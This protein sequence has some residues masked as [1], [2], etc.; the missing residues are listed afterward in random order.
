MS[1]LGLKLY[2]SSPETL[3]KP[4]SCL[5]CCFCSSRGHHPCVFPNKSLPWGLLCSMTLWCSLAS[6]CQDTLLFRA[7][8]L[9][10]GKH[11]CSELTSPLGKPSLQSCNTC[12]GETFLL[13][14]NTSTGEAFALRALT[15]NT[16]LT[17]PGSSLHQTDQIPVQS[18]TIS[19]YR[20]LGSTMQQITVWLFVIAQIKNHDW[21]RRSHLTIF[22][23]VPWMYSKR[24]VLQLGL[25]LV[26]VL[27]LW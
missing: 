24:Q 26:C 16:V 2:Q 23:K 19:R 10:L 14:A 13:R 17:N 6:E 3:Y 5:P 8:I 20:V 25:L 11:C 21:R 12:T 4:A 22:P 15:W 27:L 18:T 7:V 1:G 9:G